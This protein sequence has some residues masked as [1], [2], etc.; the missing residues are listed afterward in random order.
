MRCL[1]LPVLVATAG[2]ARAE[3][4]KSYVMKAAPAAA[5]WGVGDRPGTEALVFAFKELAP[6]TGELPVPGPR[7]T[8]SVTQWDLGA[9][10]W[11]RRQWFGDVPLAPE[12]FTVSADLGASVLEATVMGTLE[13]RSETGASLYPEVPGKV[14]I[15]WTA[16][17]GL[18]NSMLAYIYQTP[19]YTAQLKSQGQGRAATA[20]ATITVDAMGAPMG[21]WGFGSLSSPSSGSLLLKMP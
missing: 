13:E 4:A 5:L 10:G 3:E 20:T 12:A 19:P 8:F 11:V 7:M 15:H 1:V 2:G 6:E 14:Q 18:G 16:S 17:G 21:F 9:T